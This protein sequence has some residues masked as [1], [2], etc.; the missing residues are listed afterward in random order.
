[1]AQ[2]DS[3]HATEQ[4]SATRYEDDLYTWA[5]EQVALLRAGRLSEIDA[6][7]IAEELADVGRSE[8]RS[9]VSTFAVLIQHLLKWDH[10]P[11]RRSRSWLLTI[12]EHRRRIKADLADSP[13]LTSRLSEALERAYASARNSA[14]DET[15][16]PDE[17]IPES[18]VYTFDEIMTRAID[19]PAGRR[20]QQ[21]S[22]PRS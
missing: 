8:F 11:D 16:L 19:L 22:S 4:H 1:M 5:H 20:K 9:L 21:K 3:K 13:G 6:A 7:N 18:C 17:A 15:E 12:R 2:Q 14:L 10:Q